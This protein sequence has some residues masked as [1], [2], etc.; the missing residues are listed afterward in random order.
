MNKLP[1]VSPCQLPTPAL[2]VPSRW[3]ALHP[4]ALLNAERLTGLA[5]AGTWLNTRR[6]E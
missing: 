4:V 5:V 3:R 6:S 1:H 2:P